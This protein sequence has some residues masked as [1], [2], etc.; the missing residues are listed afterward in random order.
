MIGK[1]VDLK[2]E[3]LDTVGHY[4]FDSTYKPINL[5]GSLYG[6]S[7]KKSGTSL[8]DMKTLPIFLLF[9]LVDIHNCRE[10][11]LS[12]TFPFEDIIF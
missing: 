8:T 5:Y 9:H 7:M 3:I 1:T 6:I 11:Y 12:F 10:R 4:C 2:I